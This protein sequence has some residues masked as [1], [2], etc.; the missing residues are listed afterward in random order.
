LSCIGFPR[1]PQL[2]ELVTGPVAHH[3]AAVTNDISLIQSPS[4][5]VMLADI[6]RTIESK[7]L[8]NILRLKKDPPDEVLHEVFQL[9]GDLY[10]ALRLQQPL[11]C[12]HSLQRS[13]C[14]STDCDCNE[15]VG[16]VHAPISSIHPDFNQSFCKDIFKL[17]TLKGDGVSNEPTGFGRYLLLRIP[18]GE[19]L[20]F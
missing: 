4:G 19:G 17:A 18:T 15:N 9:A 6:A 16:L 1:H 13:P 5:R 2:F 14:A 12:A 3:A 11:D 7:L 8:D 20:Q 10:T